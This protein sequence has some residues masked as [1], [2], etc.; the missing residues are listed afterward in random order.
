MNLVPGIFK[1]EGFDTGLLLHAT[2]VLAFLVL[3]VLHWALVVVLLLESMGVGMSV[4]VRVGVSMSMG[5]S[6]GM[7]VGVGVGVSVSVD[8]MLGHHLQPGLVRAHPLHGFSWRSLTASWSWT[9]RHKYL[10]DTIPRVLEILQA[11]R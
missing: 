9:E 2:H 6:V 1:L 11:F 3:K 8:V 7:G 10:K 4:G 5:M